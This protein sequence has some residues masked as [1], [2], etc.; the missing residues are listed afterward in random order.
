MPGRREARP[1]GEMED[2]TFLDDADLRDRLRTMSS[3]DQAE[4][5][6]K[7]GWLDR[8][9]IVKN[10]DLADEVVA[11]MPD[12][13]ILLTFK[14]AGE[15]SGLAVLPYCS[16]E[17]LRFVLDI[18]LWDD[19]AI[20]EESVL[21]WLEY[22]VSAGEKTIVEF[23]HVCDMELLVV[24]L[25]KLVRL[26]PFDD[27]VEMGEE[28][29][30]IMPDEAFVVQPRVPEETPAIRLLLTTMMVEDRDLYSELR[31]SIYRAIPAEMEE[32]AYRWRNSRLEEKGILEYGEAAKIYECPSDSEVKGI[33]EGRAHP[34]YG[35]GNDIQ[36]PAFYPLGLSGSRPLYYDLLVALGDHEV[37]DRISGDVSYVTNR[38]LIADGRT[39]GDV[40]ATRAALGRLFSLAN[41]GL[42]HV[43]ERSGCSPEE[44][45]ESVS[46][47]DLFRIGLGLVACIKSEADE[48]GA[49]C[50]SGSESSEYPLL[51]DYHVGVLRGLRMRVPRYFEPGATATEDYRDFSTLEEVRTAAKVL[52]Q[53]SVLFEAFHNKLGITKA[54]GKMDFGNLLMTG[55]ARFVLSNEFDV[56]PL[57]RGELSEFLN[58]AFTV[59]EDGCRSLDPGR[60][61]EYLA[62][63][64]RRTGLKGHEWGILE[65]YS[66]ER[67]E[68]LEEDLSGAPTAGDVDPLLIESILLA[69]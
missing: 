36:V 41:V 15:D 24:F 8:V 27:A 68:L 45:L 23:M 64:Q 19:Y 33:V 32:E 58:A 5:F 28:L 48:I 43:A 9:K 35:R 3:E 29:T 69:K 57:R 50:S 21:K 4:L 67:L 56:T 38:L 46:I 14:G 2:I 62:W 53:I 17:Q 11:S 16:G 65:A 10:S 25:G 44:L 61:E 20:A 22:L 7:S 55:F 40:E 39:V 26:I 52:E 31:Y 60:S 18:D 63:L 13:E 51:E 30:S 1:V 49:M 47:S 59:G 34:Y 12:E 42:L 54:D 6:R 66:M 37:R